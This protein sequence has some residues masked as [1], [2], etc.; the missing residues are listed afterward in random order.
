MAFLIRLRLPLTAFAAC[1]VL[2]LMAMAQT[3]GNA[4]SPRTSAPTTTTTT[5]MKIEIWS[6][7]VCPFCYLGKR[8]F[9]TALEAFEH[10]DKIEIEYKSFQ[11]AP[12]I[13]TD[14][15][16]R[17]DEYLAS[18]KGFP[19]EQARA[20]NARV[21]A[22]ARQIGLDYHLDKAILA[23]TFKAHKV[24]HLAKDHGVQQPMKERLLHA[25]F[26]EALNIDDDATLIRLAGEVGL[27]AADVTTALN[28]TA[29]DEAVRA[30]IDLARKF[31]CTGVPFYVFD[32]AYAV[33]GAQDVDVF[34]ETLRRSYEEF[35]ANKN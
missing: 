12:D 26:T 27:S 5:T 23:N 28:G 25:Y 15:T 3:T 17:V 34:S 2:P 14:T 9:E 8:K 19:I 21:T 22:A 18:A 33:S 13:V 16:L 10:R 1:F 11:L 4:T 32:R 20:M 29:Y 35:V 7:I 24:L 30:D 6:D 31:G